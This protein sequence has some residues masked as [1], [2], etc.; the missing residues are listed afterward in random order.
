MK[1]GKKRNSNSD[2]LQSSPPSSD[3]PTSVDGAADEDRRKTSVDSEKREDAEDA[4]EEDD[5][6]E[7]DSEA[8]RDYEQDDNAQIEVQGERTKL[9]DGYYEIEAVRRKR[10]RKGQVQYLIK[11][12][13]WSEAANTWEPVENLLQCSDIIDAFEESLKTGKS[14]S[15]RKRK[16]KAGVTYVQTKKKLHH[17]HHHQQ[18]QQ[19]Q[20]QP[21][22]QQPQQQPPQ[23][24]SPAAATYNVPSHVIR[25]AEEPISFPRLNDLS[26]TNGNGENSVS[27]TK[28]V[29]TSKKVNENGARMG[30]VMR[31]EDN[32]Q[33]ELDLKLC[34]LK[35]AMVISSEDTDRVAKTSQEVH[36]TGGDTLAIGL[37][38][39]DV[40]DA[41]HL[42]RCTGAKKRKSGFVKRFKKDPESCS[43]D[44]ASNGVPACASLV[45]IS[46]QQPEFLGNNMNCKSKFEDS[47]SMCTI[48]EIV[49]PISYKASISNNIQEV[50]VAFE[51]TRSD[52]TKVIVD[53]KFLKANNPLLVSFPFFSCIFSFRNHEPSCYLIMCELIS[54]I[55]EG[56]TTL[57]FF[58]QL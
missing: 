3:L 22:Q 20:Q 30:S 51:A 33:N 45:P 38:K 10:V 7:E 48:T 47:K 43:V 39:T 16:R 50:L 52:G 19:Q 13:G 56:I 37:R 15:T 1:G 2:P 27:V 5:G 17:H 21:Q 25:I 11:W 29:E 46:I 54:I 58:L 14:R 40:A 42:G 26:C 44:D 35:G 49:K 23:Q 12:R 9:A 34:E 28:S 24:R 31:E 6:D 36:L 32:E 41:V 53:N 4:V 8:E 57:F 18:Q 55:Y